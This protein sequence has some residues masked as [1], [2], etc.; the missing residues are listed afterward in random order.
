MATSIS[1]KAEVSPKARIGDNCKIYPFAYIED[2]VVIGDNCVIY[3]YVSIMNGTRMGNDNQVF[4][5]TVLG[6]MPQD[7]LYTGEESQL[8]IGDHN[9]F[10]ENVVVNRATHSDGQTKIG[11][12]NF[13]MEGTHLSHDVKVGT[14]CVLGYGVKI[15]G[16]CEI[17]DG[18]ILCSGVIAS[19]KTRVG[20]F[21]VVQESCSFARDIP[22][23]VIAGGN[24][25]AYQGPNNHMMDIRLVPEKIQKHVANAYRLIFHG[26]NSVFDS[27]LQVNAQV[28]DS[29]EIR[30]IVDFIQSTKLGIIAKD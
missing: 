23:Y 15:A 28:P 24:P 12:H 8:V 11:N 2:D 6:A 18:S 21:A 27:V 14:H 13:L 4:Q 10:R 3:P 1:P 25:I 26:Q 7:F 30:A 5:N 16:D 20:K 22:P 17:G 29:P 9:T 19:G